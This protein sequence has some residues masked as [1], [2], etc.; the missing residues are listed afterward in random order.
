MYMKLI[1]LRN[2]TTKYLW[3]EGIKGRLQREKIKLDA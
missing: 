1:Q 3:V 2:P